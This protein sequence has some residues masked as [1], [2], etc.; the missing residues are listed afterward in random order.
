M[1]KILINISLLIHNYIFKIYFF[2]ISFLYQ[3]F[4]ILIMFALNVAMNTLFPFE[5]VIR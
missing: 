5:E 3:A 4:S 2:S 1:T